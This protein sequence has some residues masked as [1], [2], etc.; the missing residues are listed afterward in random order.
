MPAKLSAIT[1][2]HTMMERIAS[3]Y[4]IKEMTRI[5]CLD[6]EDLRIKALLF[7]PSFLRIPQS[8]NNDLRFYRILEEVLIA[9]QWCHSKFLTTSAVETS[10]N[11]THVVGF[12]DNAQ[13]INTMVY[14]TILLSQ[15]SYFVNSIP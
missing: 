12:R 14:N 5:I 2:I 1:Y 8:Q 15:A 9:L 3:E 4:I 6:D 13:K 10:L 7:Y 11:T